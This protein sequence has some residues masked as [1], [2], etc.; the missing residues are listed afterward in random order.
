MKRRVALGLC[1]CSLLVSSL[2]A[3]L[4]PQSAHVNLYFPQLADG[5]TAQQRWQTT[6]I[7]QN[8]HPTVSAAVQLNIR[9]NDGS[10]LAIDF[11]SGP[12]SGGS[13]SVPAGGT[14]L[15]RSLGTAP[16]VV[17]GWAIATASL[18]LHATVLFRAIES[19]TP[20]VDIAA[21]PTLPAPTFRS[22][23]NADLGIALAN[24]YS[25]ATLAIQITAYDPNGTLVGST[26]V[27][28]A[29][30]AHSSFNLRS[31]LT[32]L[33]AGFVGT[34]DLSTPNSL[35]F[36]AW[37][38]NSQDGVLSSLPPGGVGWPISHY[39]RIWLA[40]WKVVN[41][42]RPVVLQLAGTDLFNPVVPL[43]LDPSQQIN[44][45]ASPEGRIAVTYALS[46]LISDSPSELGFAIGHELGH[47]VQF[48]AGRQFFDPVKEHDADAFGML[49]NLFAGYDPYAG[50]GTLA[51]INMASGTAGLV[52]ELLSEHYDVHGSTTTRLQKMY[53]LLKTICA[54]PS[55]GTACAQYKGVIHPHFPSGA[56]L[57]LPAPIVRPDEEALTLLATPANAKKPEVH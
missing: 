2:S 3:Q 51:K 19:G 23:A 13:F 40:Y 46:E 41:A 52:N 57:S 32:S 18:P 33:P 39:D 35:N 4:D 38:L 17:T 9:G 12:I 10:P 54:L 43:D 31:L 5:G 36:V 44:A 26:S 25:D 34:L 47:I 7:F 14:R 29:P 6:F 56:P 1:L 21:P 48:R 24:P 16:N 45:F 22:F 11:G 55:V 42:A 49:F 8:P 27:S 15:L 50:A 30:R 37:T 28:L 20:R 53:Q